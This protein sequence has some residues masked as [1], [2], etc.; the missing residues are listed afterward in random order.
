MNHLWRKA[1][2]DTLYLVKINKK[3]NKNNNKNNNFDKL[4]QVRPLKVNYDEITPC[5]RRVSVVWDRML[6]Q[7]F[8]SLLLV[9]ICYKF[10]LLK[11]SIFLGVPRKRRGQIWLYLIH[12]WKHLG[13]HQQHNYSDELEGRPYREILKNW[14]THQHA[15]LID[16][17]R[18]FP[19]HPLFSTQLGAGQIALFNILKAY[20]LIDAQVGYCQGISFVAGV[21]LMHAPEELSFKL[22]KHLMFD[23]GLRKQYEMD[24]IHLQIKLYQLSRLVHDLHRDLFEHLEGLEINPTLYA[25]SWFLTVFSSQFPLGFVARVFDLIF[26]QGI[27]VITKVALVLLGNHKE[28]IKQCQGFEGTVDFLKTTL[29][30][31]GIIQM[32][33]IINQVFDMDISRQLQSY[34]S[35]YYLLK[36]EM[37]ALKSNSSTDA[38][39][40]NVVA[41]K[42]STAAT[43]TAMSSTNNSSITI[44]TFSTTAEQQRVSPSETSATTT[45][46]PATTTLTSATTTTEQQHL[47]QLATYC[48]IL[49]D[50]LNSAQPCLSEE[51][52]NDLNKIFK[53][54]PKFLL[55]Q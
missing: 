46:A 3:N 49:E 42:T 26:L 53:K 50:F 30:E 28:L 35:E 54:K 27:D 11:C 1:I 7:N 12:Q 16:L 48:I 51:L 18:T 13:R 38:A 14:S 8:S 24:M 15:I 25:A 22:L 19:G 45:L 10:D 34:K 41:K 29:P 9:S 55:N 6:K 40:K 52:R 43:I 33:R 39:S 47:Q 32:E 20:S 23:L 37:M 21:L 2:A 44:T 36:D 4:K 5:L 31:M 17:G